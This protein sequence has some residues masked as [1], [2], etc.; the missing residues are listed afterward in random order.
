[1]HDAK[2]RGLRTDSGAQRIDLSLNL[3]LRDGG[4]EAVVIRF[5]GVS[6]LRM[7]TTDQPPMLGEGPFGDL[8]YHE[9]DVIQDRFEFRALFSSGAEV[10]IEFAEVEVA[11]RGD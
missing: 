2:F 1:M 10:H 8:G 6:T 3:C 5:G 11:P 7:L 9:I 4:V